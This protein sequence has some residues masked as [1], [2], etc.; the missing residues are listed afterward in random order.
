[1]RQR[2]RRL[3]RLLDPS[4]VGQ[5]ATSH[6]SH[7][8][9]LPLAGDVVRVFFSSRDA[10]NRSRLGSIDLA[11]RQESIERVSAPRG[12]LL[13]PGPR[14]AFDADGITASSFL[15][16]GDR[17]LAYYLG[18][19]VGRNVPFSNFVGIA[20]G[21]RNGDRFEKP[22][23]APIVGR[24]EVNPFSL[25]YPWVLRVGALWRMWLGSHV[26]WGPAGLD[27]VAVIKTADSTDGIAWHASPR[28]A[29]NLLA[30][31]DPQE[32]ALSRPVVI[33][34]RAGYS[35]W[36]ARRYPHYR[37]GYAQSVDGETWERRDHEILMTGP[38]GVWEALE[39]T[40]PCVFDH[41][42]RRYL[43][44]NGD[45]YGQTGFGIAILD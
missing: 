26:S 16:D 37:L 39:M 45:G 17:L 10:S 5:W 44:Y 6:A 34:E 28:V 18:W 11:V 19:S 20:V 40:Y 38:V 33:K 30:P 8:T 1:V 3:G 25:G 36:Y 15:R 31:Q 32:F 27:M 2:W 7:P 35:M 13:Q 22:F 42:G 41:G 21:D 29:I 12:P 43:L 14:G 24:S 9:A 23:L 4:E